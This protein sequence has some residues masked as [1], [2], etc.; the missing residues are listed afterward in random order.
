[1]AKDGTV[2]KNNT[3]KLTPIKIPTN[4]ELTKDD[5]PYEEQ[6]QTCGQFYLTTTLNLNPTYNT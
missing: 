3:Q 6:L 1:M 2:R 4:P 5:L